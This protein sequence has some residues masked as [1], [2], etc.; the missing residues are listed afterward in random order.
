MAYLMSIQFFPYLSQTSSLKSGKYCNARK[1][2]KAK[3][4][5]RDP[6]KSH[7]AVYYKGDLSPEMFGIIIYTLETFT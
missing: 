7:S 4:Q 2:T 3:N 1:G 5:G 6:S